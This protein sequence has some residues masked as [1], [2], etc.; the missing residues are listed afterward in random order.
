MTPKEKRDALLY[1]LR[2]G[3]RQK[4]AAFQGGKDPITG[5]GLVESFHIDHDHVSGK[6]RGALNPWSN[7][8]LIDSVSKL[9]AMLNY[10]TDPP[11]PKALGETVYGLIGRAQRKRRMKYGPNGDPKPHV[12]LHEK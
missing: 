1:N 12:R 4:I 2:P 7:K 10:V 11:A 9:K 6:I 8:E 3:E 5:D